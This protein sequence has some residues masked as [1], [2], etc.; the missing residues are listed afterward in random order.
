MGQQLSLNEKIHVAICNCERDVLQKL[1]AQPEFTSDILD[2]NMMVEL[3]HKQ[4]EN[5]VI[6]QFA[7]MASDDQLASLIAT[8][9]L[10]NCVISL[11]KLFSM[12]KAPA[13]TIEKHHLKELFLTVCD[14]GNTEAVNE[15]IQHQCYDPQDERPIVVVFRTAMRKNYGIDTEL[16]DVVLKA[17]PN[18]PEA[19]NYLLSCVKDET[20]KEDVK[21]LV[22]SKLKEYLAS[23]C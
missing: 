10:H 22:E 13:A 4:W 19:A 7:A 11:D 20:K 21:E 6:Y 17:L 8:A 16:L 18:H 15:L 5:E 14:R 12:M 9:I 3:I 2:V 23:S 1:M